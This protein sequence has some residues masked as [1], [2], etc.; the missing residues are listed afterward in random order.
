MQDEPERP[1]RPA[2]EPL[3]EILGLTEEEAE[4]VRN[5]LELADVVT[6]IPPPESERTDRANDDDA[7]VGGSGRHPDG[8]G[9]QRAG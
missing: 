2:L 3:V 6:G 5:Q 1:A 9:P 8:G 4:L 7:S